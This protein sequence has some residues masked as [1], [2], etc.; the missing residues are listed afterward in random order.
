MLDHP[1]HD[2]LRSLKLDGMADGE[3][4]TAP[5]VRARRRTPSCRHATTLAISA[6]PNGSACSSTARRQAA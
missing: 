4:A 3:P 2:Q 6:M 5:P 1:T